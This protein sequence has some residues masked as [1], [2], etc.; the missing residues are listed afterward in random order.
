MK[1]KPPWANK[2]SEQPYA[3]Q[4]RDFARQH[5]LR[6]SINSGRVGPKGDSFSIRGTNPDVL[7]FSFD[8]KQTDS[9][10]YCISIKSWSDLV[11]SSARDGR[12]AVIQVEFTGFIQRKGHLSR[13][14]DTA[15]ENDFANKRGY[16]GHPSIIIMV[17]E[18]FWQLK[19]M[20]EAIRK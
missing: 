19:E 2:K 1:E 3:R 11:I 17:E 9:G 7:R 6:Q 15:T 20:A 12:H 14:V 8:N 10:R 18:D 13:L 4:E 16:G 5:T